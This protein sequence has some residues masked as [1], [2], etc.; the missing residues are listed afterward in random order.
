MTRALVTVRTLVIDGLGTRTVDSDTARVPFGG[1]GILIKR[2]PYGGP[3][4][5]FRLTVQAGR[6]QPSGLSLTLS[7]EVWRGDADA[8]PSPHEISHREEAT[9]VAPGSSYLFEIDHDPATD[10]R[11]VLSVG[12]RPV[13]EES[14]GIQIPSALLTGETRPVRLLVEMIRESAGRAEQP[15]VHIL[16]TMMGRPVSYSSGIRSAPVSGEPERF[17]GLTVTLT[18]ERAQGDLVTIKVEMTGAEYMDEKRTRLEPFSRTEVRTVTTGTPFDLMLRLP[19]EPA[20]GERAPE[21]TVRII[22]TLLVTPE[23]G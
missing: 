22:W 4:L 6:P 16:E 15:D 17:A 7:A 1:K 3:P 23:L 8:A 19:P 11:I 9:V 20:G 10:R 14:P 5:S 2:V 13:G 21:G 12:A 18:P